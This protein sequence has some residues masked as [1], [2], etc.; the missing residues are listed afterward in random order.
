MEGNTGGGGLRAE[1]SAPKWPA[2]GRRDAEERARGWPSFQCTRLRNLTLKME[3][4][5]EPK[6]AAGGRNLTRALEG[7]HASG[8]ALLAAAGVEMKG[9]AEDQSGTVS[10]LYLQVY[11]TLHVPGSDTG[12]GTTREMFRIL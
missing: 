3:L 6:R 1:P 11:L 12:R 4:V 5:G 10:V 8:R 9:R 7:G 2:K